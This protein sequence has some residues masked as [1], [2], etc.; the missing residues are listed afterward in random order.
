VLPEEMKELRVL[1][2]AM[3]DELDRRGF[4]EVRTPALEYGRSMPG[5]QLGPAAAY[6]LLDEHGDDL[7]LRADMTIPIARIATTRYHGEPRPLRFCYLAHTW[8]KVKP[9]AGASREVLQIG[10]ELI[11]E[12][13]QA[14]ESEILETLAGVLDA[15]GL[16]DWRIALGD[17]DIVPALLEESGLA[18]AQRDELLELLAAQDLAGFDRVAS[19]CEHD[20]SRAI[21]AAKGRFPAQSQSARSSLEEFGESGSGM[22]GL[23]DSLPSA[24]RDRLI[25]DLGLSPRIAYYGGL[26]FEIYDP[27]VGRPVGG[28]GRYDRLLA[29][30]GTNAVAVGFALD[31]EIIHAALAGEKRGEHGLGETR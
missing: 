11:S 31:V 5:S 10:A 17:A 22:I 19:S 13:P 7:V 24:L 30:M 1:T 25:L 2:R 3:I 18:A 12:D 26:V 6:R 4:G 27:A 28:G 21:A 9:R 16:S 20:L 8:R 23:I 29:E 14:A 15:A